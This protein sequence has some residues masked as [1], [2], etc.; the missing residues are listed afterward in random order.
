MSSFFAIF[1]VIIVYMSLQVKMIS[2]KSLSEVKIIYFIFKKSVLK[3]TSLFKV[4]VFY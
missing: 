2:L 3:K 4:S 1:F